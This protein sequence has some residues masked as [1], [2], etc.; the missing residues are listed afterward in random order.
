M[1]GSQGV[2]VEAALDVLRRHAPFDRMKA[3]ARV[4]R[5]RYKLK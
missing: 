5:G 4:E 2:M 1:A 3:Q